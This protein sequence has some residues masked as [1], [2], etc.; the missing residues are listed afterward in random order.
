MNENAAV[1]FRTIYIDTDNELLD[2]NHLEGHA[3]DLELNRLRKHQYH[4]VTLRLHLETRHHP[5]QQVSN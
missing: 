4:P 5:L 1:I 3:P 2:N